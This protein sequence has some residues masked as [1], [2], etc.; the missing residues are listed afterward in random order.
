M[1]FEEATLQP[2]DAFIGLL[3]AYNKDNHE[4]LFQLCR[5]NMSNVYETGKR[6]S[7]RYAYI[8]MRREASCRNVSVFVKVG[9]WSLMFEFTREGGKYLCGLLDYASNRKEHPR[10]EYLFQIPCD[11]VVDM[12]KYFENDFPNAK[13][14]YDHVS[15]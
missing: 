10:D 1:I 13:W 5:A 15:F 7:R 3:N 9:Y 2:V 4:R 11:W 6:C 12:H 14:Y 8:R